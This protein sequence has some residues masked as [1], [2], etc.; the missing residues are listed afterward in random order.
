MLTPSSGSTP[1]SP[2]VSLARS[3]QDKREA[4][5]RAKRALRSEKMRKWEMDKE[6]LKTERK[7]KVKWTKASSGWSSVIE[8]GLSPISGSSATTSPGEGSTSTVLKTPRHRSEEEESRLGDT[9]TRT[10]RG[11]VTT[12]GPALT[13][14][15]SSAN[16]IPSF[17]PRKPIP[18]GS[19]ALSSL[20]KPPPPSSIKQTTDDGNGDPRPESPTLGH[21]Q[22]RNN[23]I[24]TES[25]FNPALSLE[26]G[27]NP[28]DQQSRQRYRT[29]SSDL[30]PSDSVSAAGASRSRQE[31]CGSEDGGNPSSKMSRATG[32]TPSS[33]T[34]RQRSASSALDF[35]SRATPETHLDFPKALSSWTSKSSS[36]TESPIKSINEEGHSRH[37]SKEQ[38]A[39]SGRH[40]QQRRHPGSQI[41]QAQKYYKPREG[42]DGKVCLHTHH[43]HYWIVSDPTRPPPKAH[44]LR[45][46]KN[47]RPIQKANENSR[48]D[49]A[50]DA[51]P[52][53]GEVEALA[54][55]QRPS[56]SNTNQRYFISG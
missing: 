30:N 49:G 41:S 17:I 27:P 52:S 40:G 11:S 7:R 42:T 6:A 5:E 46:S 35:R 13:M 23:T 28:G 14:A 10:L 54:E 51:W 32:E 1:S 34:S 26:V 53:E 31:R 25:T 48:F 8:P 29:L 3:V 20:P 16:S 18:K 45:S 15:T 12:P 39:T 47:R 37:E 22:H 24:P 44:G 19:H 55:M 50:M 36:A 43:H 21:W 33:T 56:S 9:A 2:F 4:Y 38:S